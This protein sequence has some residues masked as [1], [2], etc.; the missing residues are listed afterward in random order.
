MACCSGRAADA[1][2]KL[3]GVSLTSELE[4]PAS[5]LSVFMDQELPGVGSFAAQIAPGLPVSLA[6]TERGHNQANS[7]Q[8]IGAAIDYRLRL[9]FAADAVAR[10]P[11]VAAGMMC[12]RTHEGR[13]DDPD[14]EAYRQIADL[15]NDML[16]RLESMT[17]ANDPSDR[18]RPLVMGSAVEEDL[19]RLCYVAAWYDALGRTG[20]LH[21]GRT[22]A[23]SFV[24]VYSSMLDDMLDGVPNAA[25]AN[26]LELLRYAARSE[27]GELRA[28]ARTAVPGPCFAGSVDVNGADADL[29]VDDLLLEIKTHR[30]PASHLRESLRQLLG[31]MLLDYDDSHR[32]RRVG[33]YYT[34]HAHLSRWDA[35]DLIRALG[36]E[37]SLADLRR[38][39]ADALSPRRSGRVITDA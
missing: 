24:A 33:L 32:I 6:R 1:G 36:A 27:L 7:W 28:K 11:A 39:C 31:Y 26:M 38:G 8:M 16:L 30:N 17:R 4:N 35:D 5:R 34:R 21:D 23:L 22:G 13:E 9:A 15:G 12:A 18:N 10:S 29:I 3:A 19:C 20:D 25:V 2:A 14:G 37:S